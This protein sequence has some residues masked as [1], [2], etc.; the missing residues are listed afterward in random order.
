MTRAYYERKE[1]NGRS[2]LN[3]EERMRLFSQLEFG[4]S[5]RTIRKIFMLIDA[6]RNMIFFVTWNS[7]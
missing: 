3:P 2:G 1:A 4:S 6:P 5:L 7:S